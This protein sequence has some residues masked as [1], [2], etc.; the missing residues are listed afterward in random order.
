MHVVSLEHGE[1][2]RTRTIIRLLREDQFKLEES[3]SSKWLLTSQALNIKKIHMIRCSSRIL[4]RSSCFNRKIRSLLSH[5]RQTPRSF[6]HQI[7][8]RILHLRERLQFL[9]PKQ[10]MFRFRTTFSLSSAGHKI[11]DLVP[12]NLLSSE[13]Q[14]K[15]IESRWVIG[16]RSG[17][18]KARFVGKG[19]SQ[20]IDEESKYAHTP[21]A[22]TLKVILLMSQTHR[23]SVC[24]SDVAS[25]F[26]NTPVGESKGSICVQAPRE[27]QYPEPTVWRLKRQ[28]YGLKD[29]PRSWQIHL[30]QVLK[31]LNLSQ[32]RSDPCTFIGLD[33]SGHINLIVMAYVDDSVIA[34]EDH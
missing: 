25:A 1:V 27:I 23:W 12:L 6:I 28:L 16:P 14:A 11:Y 20:V 9:Q 2:L 30:N 26:L 4:F 19:Y 31:S 7:L 33:F 24:V 8:F 34:G 10:R 13:D 17:Q 15:I 18:L 5:R 21:H 32:M 3:G 22:T 29:S